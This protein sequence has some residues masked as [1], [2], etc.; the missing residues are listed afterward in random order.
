MG[1]GRGPIQKGREV[2]GLIRCVTPDRFRPLM[3]SPFMSQAACPKWRPA[4]CKGPT[5]KDIYIFFKILQ[6]LLFWVTLQSLWY[7]CASWVTQREMQCE[8]SPK[9]RWAWQFFP[10][11]ATDHVSRNR[12]KDKACPKENIY[13]DYSEAASKILASCGLENHTRPPQAKLTSRFPTSSVV[14]P[15]FQTNPTLSIFHMSSVR[16]RPGDS[17]WIFFTSF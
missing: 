4:D 11:V 16:W 17:K 15:F 13:V 3:V 5:G 6:R 2:L 9:L 12:S 7:L 10:S 8:I 14:N 1:F